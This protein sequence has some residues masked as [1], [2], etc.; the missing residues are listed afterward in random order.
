MA[1][2]VVMSIC[3]A[4]DVEGWLTL[5][6]DVGS[7]GKGRVWLLGTESGLAVNGVGLFCGSCHN[8]ECFQSKSS[9]KTAVFL[10]S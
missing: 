9:V 2:I 3:L 5:N 6:A 8:A 4:L 1:Y 7:L 10:L